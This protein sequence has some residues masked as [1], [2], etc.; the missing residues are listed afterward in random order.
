MMSR[1]DD[2]PESAWGGDHDWAIPAAPRVRRDID[3][4]QNRQAYKVL[5]ADFRKQSMAAR[6]PCW[7]CGNGIN[8]GARS[9]TPRAFELDHAIP[10]SVA[11]ELALEPSNF[12][13][14]HAV[15][16]RRR[17]AGDALSLTGEASED[18]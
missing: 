7:L 15:C 11:P 2:T 10:V 9:G 1:F 8:Y 6:A 18:W 5:R 17:Q 12:R 3:T 13:A 14:S 16:N 4:G